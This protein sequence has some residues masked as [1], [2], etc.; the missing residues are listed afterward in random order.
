MAGNILTCSSAMSQKLHDAD[1]TCSMHQHCHLC[2]VGSHTLKRASSA[3]Q[4][5]ITTACPKMQWQGACG[6]AAAVRGALY[7]AA[8]LTRAMASAAMQCRACAPHA[9]S[10]GPC[11]PIV[12][13]SCHCPLQV[14]DL[15]VHR[16]G[17]LCP[18]VPH[19]AE[20]RVHLLQDPQLQPHPAALHRGCASGT[21]LHAGEIEKPGNRL[22]QLNP[23]RYSQCCTCTPACA[24]LYL[25]SM[26]CIFHSI[27]CSAGT[28]ARHATA[29]AVVATA[30][31]AARADIAAVLCCRAGPSRHS[32]GCWCASTCCRRSWSC[33][34]SCLW[35]GT[36]C[37]ASEHHW[38]AGAALGPPL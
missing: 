28:G 26:M 25:G 34:P 12:H 20:R 19:A 18:G 2:S 4:K 16:A 5:G 31:T 27:C 30:S 32:L 22:V 37:S 17:L 29:H 38:L 21:V 1:G 9:H 11:H 15:G 3:S 33:S 13:M 14:A 24:M 6:W 36:M 8:V 23:S 35:R 10:S 7:K